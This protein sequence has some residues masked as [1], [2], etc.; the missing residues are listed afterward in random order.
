MQ[1]N[2]ILRLNNFLITKIIKIRSGK[3]DEKKLLKSVIKR[4]K[5]ENGEGPF[6]RC[7]R[8]GGLRLLKKE[9]DGLG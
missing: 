6:S 5:R 8:K 2:I 7:K 9:G 1:V 3:M 4:K